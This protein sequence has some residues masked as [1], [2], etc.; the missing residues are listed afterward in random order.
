MEIQPGD[1]GVVYLTIDRENSASALGGL[2]RF[3]GT[4]G[5]VEEEK[6]LFDRLY[7]LRVPIEVVQ[8]LDEPAA[9]APYIEKLS[10]IT[11][12]SWGIHLQGQPAKVLTQG[13]FAIL[14]RAIIEGN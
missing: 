9:F 13:D 7:P 1:D 8:R 14:K 3:T 5:R 11:Q 4:V 2:V 10:F 6:T 12:K